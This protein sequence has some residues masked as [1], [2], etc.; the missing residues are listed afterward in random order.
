M[1]IKEAIKIVERELQYC[2]KKIDKKTY[3]VGESKYPSDSDFIY[4]AR[5]LINLAKIWTSEGRRVLDKE[6]LKLFDRK[7]NR[8]KTNQ[9]IHHEEFDKFP[10]G[11]IY[12][13]DVWSWD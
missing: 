7:R 12:K 5:E 9:A 10:K 3:S 6:S 4:T 11:K 2:V 13:E 1:G 8:Q